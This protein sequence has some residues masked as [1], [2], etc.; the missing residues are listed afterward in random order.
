MRRIREQVIWY[1]TKRLAA[2]HPFFH[3]KNGLLSMSEAKALLQ[4]REIPDGHEVLRQARIEL[5][6]PEPV[7]S[8]TISSGK[9]LF[10]TVSRGRYF[11]LRRGLICLS[12][13]LIVFGLF[14]M[15]E[16]GTAFAKGIY[17]V[18]VSVFD[19]SL[20][21]RNEDAEGYVKPIDFA[22]LP[23]EFESLE[24]VA[25]ATGRQIVIPGSSDSTMLSFT[26]HVIGQK[27][28][29]VK[30]QYIVDGKEYAVVQSFYNDSALWSGANSTT[31]DS[32][33]TIELAIGIKA[34]LSTMED[35]TVYA[36][37]FDTGHDLNISS[38]MLSIEE[39][40]EVIMNLKYVS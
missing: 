35:G 1:R 27:M 37:A 10:S 5:G 18:I 30:S 34:Y 2:A 33:N 26:A 4:G 12:V 29:V 16:A 28:L 21:S 17:N 8:A 23:A 22:A 6:I 39:L 13:L 15:T 32:I 3:R 19:G 36:E 11:V 7:S 38:T 25:E 24:A 20:L 40:K 9:T 14:T 31:E